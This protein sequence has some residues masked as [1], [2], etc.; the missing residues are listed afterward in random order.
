M[1][2]IYLYNQNS[3]KGKYKNKRE[4]II[5]RL[6][7]KFDIIDCIETKSKD[8]IINAVKNSC[9]YYDAIIFS[10]GDGTVNDIVNAVVNCDKNINLGYIPS[11]TCNDFATSL[12]IPKKLDKALDIIIKGEPKS[13]DIFKVNDRYGVYV[14]ATGIFTSASYD[15]N[16]KNKKRLG[17]LAY[18]LHSFGEIFSAR[19]NE[20]KIEVGGKEYTYNSVLTLLINS[21]SVAGYKINKGVDLNDGEMELIAI[22]QKGEKQKIS[23][24]S[25]FKVCKLFLFGIKSVKNSKNVLYCKFSFA[26]VK[27]KSNCIINIDGENGGVNDFSIKVCKDAV[28]FFA[29]Q[30]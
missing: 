23:F 14:C 10:G 4:Y 1:N 12:K 5:N 11:G 13:Y 9:G 7:E 6:H 17:K 19:A 18:Y 25:L 28:K 20:I 15:T 16:Q 21:S 29:L 2:C 30:N 24:K 27:M 22:M 3:G 26:N 8:E